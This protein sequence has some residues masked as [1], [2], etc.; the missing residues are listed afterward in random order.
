MSTNLDKLFSSDKAIET[1]G[2]WFLMAENVEFKMKRFGGANS[3]EV[4]KLNAKYLGKYQKLISKGLLDK[5]VE[6]GLYV[7]VFVEASMVDWKGLSDDEG[8]DIPFTKEAAQ[9]LFKR[10]PDLL[11][12]AMEFSMDKEEYREDLG[13]S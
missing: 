10:L 12:L 13:N 4:N 6:A 9:D 5:E 8:N 3:V 7:K 2:K 11:D 1:D